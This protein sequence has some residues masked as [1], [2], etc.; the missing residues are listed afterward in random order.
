ME[1]SNLLYVK[2][3]LF[4]RFE[5]ALYLLQGLNITIVYIARVHR[6]TKSLKKNG[7]PSNWMTR[8]RDEENT[9]R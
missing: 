1:R 8:K 5:Q 7:D 6:I 4:E 3:D 9:G 2:L